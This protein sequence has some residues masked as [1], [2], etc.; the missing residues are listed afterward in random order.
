MKIEYRSLPNKPAKERKYELMPKTPKPA[1][2][3]DLGKKS[4]DYMHSWKQL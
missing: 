2:I 3:G 4:I 1:K